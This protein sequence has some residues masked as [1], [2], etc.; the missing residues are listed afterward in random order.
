MPQGKIFMARMIWMGMVGGWYDENNG[1]IV[2][3][4]I[5]KGF[6]RQRFGFFAGALVLYSVDSPI[7]EPEQGQS[8]GLECRGRCSLCP[9]RPV[10]LSPFFKFPI[11]FSIWGWKSLFCTNGR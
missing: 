1:K 6:L 9:G 5:S 10:T 7:C 2:Q 4:K 3:G 8:G 11:R